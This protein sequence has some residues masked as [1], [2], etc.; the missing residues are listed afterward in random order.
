MPRPISGRRFVA[1]FA[2]VALSFMAVAGYAQ[3][4]QAAIDRIAGDIAEST[5]PSIRRLMSVRAKLRHVQLLLHWQLVDGE[6]PTR[7]NTA[8]EVYSRLRADV[9]AYVNLPMVPGEDQLWAE[10]SVEVERVARTFDEIFARYARG[11]ERGAVALI[12][13]NLTD[14]ADAA[15]R[16]IDTSVDFIADE[17]ARMAHDIE[18]IRARAAVIQGTLSAVAT[19]LTILAGYLLLRT[20]QQHTRLLEAHGRLLERRADEL[21]QFAGRVAHDIL[22]PL[23]TTTLALTL[24]DRALP[25]EGHAHAAVARGQRSVRRVQATVDGLL[26]FARGGARPEPGVRTLVA[27]VLDDLISE[28]RALAEARNVEVRAAASPR[29]AVACSPGVFTSLFGNLIENAIKYMGEDRLVRR[30]EVRVLERGEKLRIEVIDTGPGIASELL[31]TLFEPYSRGRDAGQPGI[32]LGLATVRR[33]AE[34]H[35]GAAGVESTPGQGST[36]WFELPRA[37]E[38]PDPTPLPTP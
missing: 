7:L 10:V 24:A 20:V 25:P 12:Q 36:F 28:A 22:S 19:V 21:E 27:P 31:P 17:S 6:R 38:P 34:T 18:A 2:A 26:H 3:Y 1:V 37:P 16:A 30:V 15:A 33:I 8:M 5:M 9:A 29:C 4:V 13:T 32:G 11:D 35:G 14:E 23:Q